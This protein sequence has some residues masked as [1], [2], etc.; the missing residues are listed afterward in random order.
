MT[1]KFREAI[2]NAEFAVTVEMIPGR[3]ASEDAQADEFKAMEGIYA[4]GR[5]HALSIT[6]NPGGNP[7]ILADQIARDFAKRDICALVHFTCKDKNRNQM[8]AQLYALEREGLQNLLIMSGDYPVSGFMGR[9]KPVFDLDPVQTLLLAQDM[10]EGLVVQGPHGASQEKPAH[11]FTGAVVNPF[12]YTE[13][14]VFT[15]YLK[16][17][18]KI[19]AGAE[20]IITQL[21]YDARKMQELLGYVHQRGY[22]TPLIANVFILSKGAARLMQQGAIAGCYISD[23]LMA[24]LEAEFTA[25]DKGRAAR[26]ERAA[27]QI[28]LAKGMGFSG[29]HIGGFG[30]DAALIT[31]ILDRADELLGNW[32]ALVGAM[33]FGKA[34][35]FYLYDAEVDAL[36]ASTG[37]NAP[38]LA[39]T[40]DKPTDGKVYKHYRL[41]RLLHYWVLT[42]GK[43]CFGL[44]SKRMDSKEHKK[45]I[46][47]SHSLEHL[48]KTA[49]YG[50]VDCGDCGLEACAYSCPMAECPK[51][52][53]NGPCGGSFDGGWCEVYPGE[54]YCIHYMAYYRLKKYGEL[55]K[56]ASFATPPNNWDFN[57][58]SGWSN[59]TH[60]RDN[61]AGRIRVS[62]GLHAPQ[63][64][65]ALLN[66][67]PS[68]VPS[69]VPSSTQENEQE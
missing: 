49:F 66:D 41:S 62:I 40:L 30:L 45:G 23:E 46:N 51:C 24:A 9:A 3:G 38:A 4:T 65:S 63:A 29:V 27:T 37:L 69:S 19:L 64:E 67:A 32:R 34:S 52:Q 15:Q 58:T 12:K 55:A 28:A 25:E 26:L 35:G 22:T 20:F 59:F 2:T 57:K 36:G 54:R 13:G 1:N 50:C 47:R 8:Q 43:R 44:L 33:S 11:F 39:A 68:S 48:S 21:G 61:A 60:T 53:R 18:R 14:E 16:L 6:D 31:D 5:V 7:A 56:L 17:E 42:P 10:N